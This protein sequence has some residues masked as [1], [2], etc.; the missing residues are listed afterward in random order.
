ML[1]TKENEFHVVVPKR[2]DTGFTRDLCPGGCDIDLDIEAETHKIDRSEIHD[3]VK[4]GV[5]KDRDQRG[6]YLVQSQAE[7]YR[8]RKGKIDRKL[9]LRLYLPNDDGTRVVEPTVTEIYINGRRI[10]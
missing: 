5:K 6:P 10:K 7:V 9:T 8:N 4:D 2:I 3:L 1:K